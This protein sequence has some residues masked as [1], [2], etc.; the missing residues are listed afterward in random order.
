MRTGT[1]TYKIPWS[2]SKVQTL[3]FVDSRRRPRPKVAPIISNDTLQAAGMLDIVVG[4][5]I[6]KVGG[7]GFYVAK[8]TQERGADVEQ[9]REL[10]LN[11]LPGLL[12]CA[13]LGVYE[14]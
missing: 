14:P 11:V 10:D 9:E 7:A 12:L 1:I 13:L 3:P 8:A 5:C 4:K 2:W 6:G